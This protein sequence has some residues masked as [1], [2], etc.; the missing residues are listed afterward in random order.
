M[1]KSLLFSVLF[2]IV[3]SQSVLA[4][5]TVRMPVV[6]KD[7]GGLKRVIVT[8]ADYEAIPANEAVVDFFRALKPGVNFTCEVKGEEVGVSL[9]DGPGFMVFEIKN[10]SP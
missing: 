3:F 6:R 7:V 2:F 4:L 5:E 9:I 8:I 1:R 10:C